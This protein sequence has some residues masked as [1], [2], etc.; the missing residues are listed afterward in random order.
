MNDQFRT[1]SFAHEIGHG[2][3]GMFHV[4]AE[5][6]GGNQASLMATRPGGTVN[7][8]ARLTPLDLEATLAVYSS[9]LGAGAPRAQLAAAGIIKR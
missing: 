5:S 6:I 2:I 9:G 7:L 3:L 1:A 8:P 4:D